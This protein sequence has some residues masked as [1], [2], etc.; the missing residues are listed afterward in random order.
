[1]LRNNNFFCR[2][3]S[4]GRKLGNLIETILVG[5]VPRFRT[6]WRCLSTTFRRHPPST[7]SPEKP[8]EIQLSLLIIKIHT[9][10]YSITQLNILLFK[11]PKITRFMI[12][13]FLHILS[14]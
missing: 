14:L 12:H 9:Q 1:M 10:K 2:L 5:S 7:S 4:I 13:R 8:A 11:T 3:L 6:G